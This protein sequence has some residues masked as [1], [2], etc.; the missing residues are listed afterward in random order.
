MEPQKPCAFCV[1]ATRTQ[2]AQGFCG[3]TKK[4]CP[5]LESLG[6]PSLG[7]KLRSKR[8]VQIATFSV[9]LED[10]EGKAFTE[11]E[12]HRRVHEVN[13][14]GRLQ[15]TLFMTSELLFFRPFFNVEHA[16]PMA[17]LANEGSNFEKHGDDRHDRGNGVAADPRRNKIRNLGVGQH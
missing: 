1:R 11:P 8:Q 13:C 2:N 10:A 12:K 4:T 3:S 9:N 14:P 6:F 17:H 7:R 15:K 16:A 5:N